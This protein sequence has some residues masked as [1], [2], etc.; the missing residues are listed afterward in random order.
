[1]STNG[2][3]GLRYVFFVF[4]LMWIVSITIFL[5]FS[6]AQL[7]HKLSYGES[8][9]KKYIAAQLNTNVTRTVSSL[10]G[11]YS[12]I[13]SNA[14]ANI[15]IKTLKGGPKAQSSSRVLLTTTLLSLGKP[16]TSDVRGNLGPPSVVTSES[17]EDW[18]GDRWQAVCGTATYCLH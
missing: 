1:M 17:M 16:V 7:K 18:L 8:I 9:F 11:N 5:M 13:N 3:V 2:N 6:Y 10:R 15:E 12:Y 4:A 14:S